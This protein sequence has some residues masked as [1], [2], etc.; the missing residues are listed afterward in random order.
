PYG[1]GAALARTVIGLLADPERGAELA[2]AGRAQAA[3]WPSEDDT[4]AQVL[5]VYDEL[6]QPAR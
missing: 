6:V 1:D 2:A 3:A 5:S 4:I